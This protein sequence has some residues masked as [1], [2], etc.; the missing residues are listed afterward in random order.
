[1]KSRRKPVFLLLDYSETL[2]FHTAPQLN[3]VIL[4]R[5]LAR[6]R[7]SAFLS[8]YADKLKPDSRL[9]TLSRMTTF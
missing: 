3:F 5:A 2:T 4:C 8:N 1:M 6:D 7:E 9:A